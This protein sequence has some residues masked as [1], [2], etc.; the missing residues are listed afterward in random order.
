MRTVTVTSAVFGFKSAPVR[1]APLR[2]ASLRVAPLTAAPARSA[3]ARSAFD[4]SALTRLAT[5]VPPSVK[6]QP[7][8]STPGVGAGVT[9]PSGATVGHVPVASAGAAGTTSD[10]D[11]TATPPIAT[12]SASRPRGRG[13]RFLNRF[14]RG[15]TGMAPPWVDAG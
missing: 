9:V 10:A 4:R 1:S 8:Q 14:R 11:D 7:L 6:S 13:M 15:S 3:S 12:A 5:A 2:S